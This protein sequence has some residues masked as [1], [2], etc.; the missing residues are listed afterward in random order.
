MQKTVIE[1]NSAVMKDPN[2]MRMIGFLPPSCA[3]KLAPVMYRRFNT[4]ADLLSPLLY[5]FSLV[6]S[7]ATLSLLRTQGL[8]VETQDDENLIS[9]HPPRVRVSERE[10]AVRIRKDPSEDLLPEKLFLLS[11]SLPISDE[12]PMKRRRRRRHDHPYTIDRVRAAPRTCDGQT[13]RMP[14]IRTPIQVQ[15]ALALRDPSPTHSGLKK[16]RKTIFCGAA[17]DA[18]TAESIIEA[19]KRLALRDKL[20]PFDHFF[21]M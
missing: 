19:R 18:I 21:K 1:H 14:D 5:S 8:G 3:E 16:S 13:D 15:Q 20:C 12:T 11:I 2:K 10:L 4:T 17:S 9:D 7:D 6:V